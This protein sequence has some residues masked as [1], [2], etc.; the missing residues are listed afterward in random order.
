VLVEEVYPSAGIT[1]AWLQVCHG[2]D[3]LSTCLAVV[4]VDAVAVRG[5]AEN[6]SGA[7]KQDARRAVGRVVDEGLR[8]LGARSDGLGA[9]SEGR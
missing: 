7:S 1:C 2:W 4:D 6:G 9:K 5:G 8:L 3:L